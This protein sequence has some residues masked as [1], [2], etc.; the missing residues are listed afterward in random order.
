MKHFKRAVSLVLA[1][2]MIVTMFSMNITSFSADDTAAPKPARYG[3][4]D[5]D[6]EVT[7]Y[8]ASDIQK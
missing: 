8:D 2:M 5:L 6:G 1:V 7:I 4:V 3:D